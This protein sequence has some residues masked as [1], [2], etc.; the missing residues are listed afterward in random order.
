MIRRLLI[1]LVIFAFTLAVAGGLA[2]RW[3]AREYDANGPLTKDT[4]VFI[5]RGSG[6]NDI[7]DRLAENG[8]I[9]RPWLFK[10]AVRLRGHAVALKAGEYLLPAGVSMSGIVERLIAGRVVHHR[11]TVPEGLTSAQVLALVAAAPL[12]AGKPPETVAEGSLLPETYFYARGDA[13]DEI[14]ARMKN[15]MDLALAAAWDKRRADFPLASGKDVLILASIVEKETS[16]PEERP[17]IA[18][19]FLNRLKLG[20][21][22]QSDP[23]VVYGLTGGNPLGRR[24]TTD[25]LATPSPYNTYL[26]DGLPPGPIANPGMDAI[27]AVIEPAQTN[28]LFFVADGSGGHVFARTLA[29]HNRNVAKWRRIKRTL[30]ASPLA[31][32]APEQKVAPGGGQQGQ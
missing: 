14:I 1:G 18:A 2:M 6:L 15:A 16:V 20:M 8:A 11:L 7:A 10:L 19:V 3:A 31:R 22:L 25:D 12:L 23:T 27:R 32:R 4:L 5:P 13:R 9:G 21:R 24:L 17:R 30:N 28:E 26:I 29:E